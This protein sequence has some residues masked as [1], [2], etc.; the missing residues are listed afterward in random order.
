[1]VVRIFKPLMALIFLVSVYGCGGGSGSAETTA[2]APLLGAALPD[3][4]GIGFLQT[5]LAVS[6]NQRVLE[7]V[8]FR[9]G[10]ADGEASI[11]Y[12]A[13]GGTARVDADFLAGNG[14]L[15][16]QHGETGLKSFSL[17]VNS[18][19]EAEPVET[20]RL[21]LIQVSGQGLLPNAATASVAISDSACNTTLGAQSAGSVHLVEPCYR[22]TGN[23][24]FATGDQFSA[25]PGATLL[26]DAGTGIVIRQGASITLVGTSDRPVTLKGAQSQTGYWT[27]LELRDSDSAANR[28]EYTHI[29]DASVG[30]S[31]NSRSAVTQFSHNRLH[32]NTLPARMPADVATRLDSA[33]SFIDNERDVVE[34]L[35]S[36]LND[37][38]S[39]PSIDVPYLTTGTIVVNGTL[40]IAAGTEL[41]FSAGD[42]LIVSTT[43]TL[44]AVGTPINPI[45]FTGDR[46]VPGHWDG[47]H[48]S[49]AVNNASVLDYVQVSYAGGD[50]TRPG[51]IA[52]YGGAP[53]I[54]IT[55]ST[56][57][58]SAGVGIW[59]SAD[60]AAINTDGTTFSGNAGQD[61]YYFN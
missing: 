32:R 8:V 29:S 36:N 17:T 50:P 24:E 25:V 12:T 28:L 21:S 60:Q 59:V 52:L 61:V 35:T 39:L 51:N 1:M 13:E 11:A 7:V 33:S 2:E 56:I 31:I 44:S 37:N 42:L 10:S 54:P 34:L 45:V 16:W 49:T 19:L 43:G 14:T 46:A 4:N 6:E 40:S 22:L 27:G 15:E 23:I 26:A 58:H 38:H 30:I 55:N 48:F 18:D 20:V 57:M 53:Q 9:A 3:E 41:Q 47:I 5:E